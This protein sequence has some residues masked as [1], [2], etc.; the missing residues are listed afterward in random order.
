M[1]AVFPVAAGLNSMSGVY[2]PE[3]WAAKTLV[4]FY[5]STVFGE[6]TNTD[7][8][9]EIKNMGDTVHIRTIP[10]ITISDYSIGMSLS[11][12]RPDPS[13]VD[14]LIDKGKYYAMAVNDVE[15]IQSDL[16]YVDKWTDDAGQ[17][18]AIKIDEAILGDVYADAHASNAGQ[19]AGAKSSAYNLGASSYPLAVDKTNVLD[20]IV[21]CGSVL[22]EQN[23][24]NTDRWLIMPA[25]LTN[26]IKK[27]DLKD[28][29]MT[30][31]AQSVL[32]N[33]RLGGVDRFEIYMSNNIDTTTD[34]SYT[35]FN[36]MFGHKCAITFA[37]QLVKNESL[38]NPNDFGDL[39][40]GLQ[41]Y[42]YETIKTEALG[43]LYAYNGG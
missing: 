16:A 27:S 36:C 43:H 29:S 11:Y 4:K 6:I 20:V 10:D 2:I 35:V 37:S 42:G 9:G 33:G 8:E 18:L 3:I 7:Y 25:I 15:K 17:Q 39:L 24:P 26:K 21:D 13:V 40:R 23:I 41:V 12:E 34:G 22:D 32:R 38:K 1:A 5:L 30:G 31:D 28:A 19:T 14:L